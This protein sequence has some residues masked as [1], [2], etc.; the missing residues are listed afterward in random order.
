MKLRSVPGFAFHQQQKSVGG[1]DEQ[2][3]PSSFCEETLPGQ[4]FSRSKSCQHDCGTINIHRLRRED[5]QTSDESHTSH[6]MIN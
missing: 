4:E 6:T 1:S 2:S 3:H 5:K